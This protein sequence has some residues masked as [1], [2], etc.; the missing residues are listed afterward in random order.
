MEE[1]KFKIVADSTGA[2]ASMKR[3]AKSTS[4]LGKS[5]QGADSSVKE[6]AKSLLSAN[7][8]ASVL[9]KGFKSLA[10]AG[11]LGLFGVGAVKG[12]MAF[13]D[14]LYDV[15]AEAQATGK[16]LDK[17]FKSGFSGTTSDAVQSSIDTIKDEIDKLERKGQKFDPLRLLL[18]GIEKFSGM[19]LGSSMDEANIEIANKQIAML[20]TRRKQV[21]A[22]E[23]IVKKNEEDAY[24]L[25][26]SNKKS[27]LRNKLFEAEDGISAKILRNAGLLGSEESDNLHLARDRQALAQKEYDQIIKVAN[28]KEDELVIKKAERSLDQAKLQTMQAQLAVIQRQKA[29]GDKAAQATKSFGGGMLGSSQAGRTAMEAAQKQRASQT[30]Q[31]NF[32]TQD[33]YYADQAKQENLKR[34]AKGLPPVTAQDMRVRE[35]EKVAAAQAPTLAEQAQAQ[36]T[37]MSAEQVA[38]SNVAQKQAIS[39][40]MAPAPADQA[41]DSWKGE[42]SKTMQA[43]IDALNALMGA[44]LVTSGAGGSK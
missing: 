42:I 24:W 27:V 31:E 10:G 6:L 28:A 36:A 23:D 30:K 44:P 2:D 37:G 41:G 4:D 11:T 9:G 5:A 40:G 12:A 43:M 8:G 1:L 29:E 16:S 33:A 22:I 19:D 15:S 21:K 13:G 18:K 25:D 17:T 38:I 34:S 32:K 35:A 3:I 26:Q 20:Q 39:S 7:S 14:A